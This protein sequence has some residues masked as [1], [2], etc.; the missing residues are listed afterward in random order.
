METLG[1]PLMV[2]NNTDPHGTAFGVSIDA[3]GTST[4]ISAFERSKTIQALSNPCSTSGTFRRPG[5][6]FPLQAK[7]GGV[8]ERRGHTEASVDLA[9]LA[10]LAPMGVICEIVKADGTMARMPQ[11]ELFAQEHG[12]H[13]VTIADLV[14][15]RR[16][17]ERVARL[18]ATFD[19]PTLHGKFTGMSFVDAVTGESHVAL[20]RGS[21]RGKGDVLVRVHSE[22]LTGDALGSLRCDCGEQ[23]RRSMEMLGKSDAG[24]LIYLRQEGRGIG[25]HNKLCAYELQDSGQDTFEANVSLGFPPDMREYHLAADI[26]RQLGVT[27]V[28][29]ITNNP[30][31]IAGLVSHGMPVIARVPIEVSASKDNC[32]YLVTKKERF[33]HLL[34]QLAPIRGC[35]EC[36]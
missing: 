22:C 10:G 36:R 4:G 18:G 2:T 7:E 21:V 13:I 5:H 23:L 9:R 12:L 32:A 24:V 6:I 3:V 30:E 20:V 16:A 26:L 15:Y 33:G 25:L 35:Q 8:L 1:I 27:G 34:T 28:R 19:A 31:K 17:T 29:L 11:L 14:R